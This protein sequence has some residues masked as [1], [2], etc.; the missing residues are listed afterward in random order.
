[1]PT[2]SPDTRIYLTGTGFDST[3]IANWNGQPLTTTLVSATQLA[4]TVPAVDFTQVG[5]ANV[6][7]TSTTAQPSP[8]GAISVE[9]NRAAR[10]A[11]HFA[12]SRTPR[13]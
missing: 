11:A 1:L 4:A 9:I 8:S 3:A 12:V 2:V 13:R 7:V 5:N 10:A 6:T